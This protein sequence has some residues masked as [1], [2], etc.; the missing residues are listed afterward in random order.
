[1]SGLN[2][3]SIKSFSDEIINSE[4]YTIDKWPLKE[5]P[6]SDGCYVFWWI[7]SEKQLVDA[8]TNANL[9]YQL[10]KSHKRRENN[11]ENYVHVSFT[12]EWIKAATKELI[13]NQP[14][15]CLY[16]G[17]ST[18]IHSR[19]SKHLKPRTKDIWRGE[20][21]SFHKKPN[22]VSQLRIGIERVFGKRFNKLTSSI[23]VSFVEMKGDKNAINRFYFE[24]RLIGTLFPLLNIDIER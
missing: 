11:N 5:L 15:I 13:N 10:K 7:G 1:M 8:F 9:K 19:V 12:S 23:A 3:E 14:A 18:N 20:E 6:K 17:K 22:T 4:K 2:L 24:E 16:V 21:V